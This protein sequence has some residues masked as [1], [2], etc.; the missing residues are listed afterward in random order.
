[1]FDKPKRFIDR[2]FIHCSATDN[3]DHDSIDVLR[4]WH[5]DGNGWSDVGY[6]YLI[7][8]DGNLELGRDLERSPAAQRGNNTGSVAICLHGLSE[9]LFTEDQYNTLAELCDSINIEL[10]GKVTFH[11]HCEVSHKS[12]PVFDYKKILDLCACGRLG[13]LDIY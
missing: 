12:C 5:V 7:N 6:H 2:V 3:P 11:G 9:D 10:K 4:H 8:A 13:W 1:M